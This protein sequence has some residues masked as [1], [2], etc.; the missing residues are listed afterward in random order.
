M[1]FRY[2]VEE[3]LKTCTALSAKNGSLCLISLPKVVEMS[4]YLLTVCIKKLY[5]K[6]LKF[7]GKYKVNP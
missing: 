5:F 6:S 4:L 3:S 1:K 7:K 2:L